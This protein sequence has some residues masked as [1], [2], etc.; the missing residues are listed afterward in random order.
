MISQ[1]YARH[2]ECPSNS[3]TFED[4][5]HLRLIQT[6]RLTMAK[7]LQNFANLT[8]FL[9]EIAPQKARQLYLVPCAEYGAKRLAL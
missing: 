5:R 3:R 2:N 8:P 1:Q 4:R 7:F 9:S 6:V